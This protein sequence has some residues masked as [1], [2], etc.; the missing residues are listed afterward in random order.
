MARAERADT[1]AAAGGSNATATTATVARMTSLATIYAKVNHLR[2][3]QGINL[4]ILC[5][6][7]ERYIPPITDQ[8]CVFIIVCRLR[9]LYRN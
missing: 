4:L 5:T 6:D 9:L 3:K 7:R 1:A 2:E 8:T